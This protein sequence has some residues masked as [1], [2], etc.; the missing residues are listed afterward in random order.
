[1]GYSFDSLIVKVESCEWYVG[2]ATQKSV[3]IISIKN[4]NGVSQKFGIA[5]CIDIKWGEKSLHC[6][7]SDAIIVKLQRDTVNVNHTGQFYALGKF[8]IPLNDQYQFVSIAEVN[9]NLVAFGIC[10][11]PK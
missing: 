4:N 9:N 2:V 7:L 10:R 3:Y 6:L 5:G 8:P 11:D 1:M